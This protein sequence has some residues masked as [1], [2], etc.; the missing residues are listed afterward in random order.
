MDVTRHARH[1]RSILVPSYDDVARVGRVDENVTRML[2]KCYEETAPVK[3]RLSQLWL[4]VQQRDISRVYKI[5]RFNPALLQL[6]LLLL[7]LA[8]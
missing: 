3:F 1:P 8:S 2:L 7:R 6:L 5:S 4:T